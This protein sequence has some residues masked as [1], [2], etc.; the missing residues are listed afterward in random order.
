MKN[1]NMPIVDMLRR[2]I[3]KEK[4]SFHMPGHKAGMVFSLPE[5]K[6]DFLDAFKQIGLYD[7]TELE[8]IDNLHNPKG[9]ILEA[10]EETEKV[11]ESSKSFF[12]VNGATCGIHAMVYSSFN[13]GDRVFVS[14]D[15]HISVFNSLMMKKV[16][17][18]V[19]PL[20]LD[21][22]TFIPLSLTIDTL[23]EA[24]SQYIDV[25]GLILTSPNYHGICPNIEEIGALVHEKAGLLLVDEAHGS[26]FGFSDKVPRRALARGA[27]MAVTSGHKTLQAFNQ[28]AFLHIKDSSYYDRVM[29]ALS[30]VETTSPSFL[31]LASLDF[32]REYMKNYGKERLDSLI[33][34]ISLFKEKLEAYPL[35]KVLDGGSFDKDPTR[36][37]ISCPSGSLLNERLVE[38]GIFV[39]MYDKNNIVLI[40]TASDDKASLD[41][42]FQALTDPLTYRALE[43][44]EVDKKDFIY[45]KRIREISLLDL[46]RYLKGKEETIPIN[47]ALGRVAAS[48]VTPYPPGIPIIFPGQK[49]G[50][51]DLISM[52]KH[53]IETINVIK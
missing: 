32:S 39:E 8:T 11:F 36:L 41:E 26:H 29:K 34:E 12:L 42:L 4:K 19:L 21:K 38:R 49:I 9:P 28:G 10:M 47:E 40:L 6:E 14:A 5:N 17:P 53:C 24:Y 37:V 44:V 27:D 33:E 45:E 31:I 48:F 30:L 25:K 23:K 16:Y 50:E 52:K 15:C 7:V 35:Y 2:H 43:R 18:I 46:D 20:E 1:F 22:E 51:S 13:E 3:E